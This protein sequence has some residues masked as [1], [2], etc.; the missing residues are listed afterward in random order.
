[1]RL[2]SFRTETAAAPLQVGLLEMTGTHVRAILSA[3]QGVSARVYVNDR[4]VDRGFSLQGGRLSVRL[5]AGEGLRF[6]RNLVQILVHKTH[7]YKRQSSYDIESRTVYI[8]RDAPIASAGADHTI[9]GAGFVQFDGR[10]TK[11]PPGWTRP[12]FRWRIVSAPKGSKAK[13][14]NASGSRPTL[15]PDRAG[16]F[17]VRVS[18]RGTPPRVSSGLVASDA[19]ATGASNDTAT[20]TVQPDIPPAGVRLDTLSGFNAYDDRQ[21]R[22][23]G[24]PVPG[25]GAPFTDINYAVIDRHTL[26]I[27]TSGSVGGNLEGIQQLGTIIDGYSG[28]L[29]YLVVLNW[30]S[31]GYEIDAER[32]A[33]DTVL[34]KI[35]SE[36]LTDPQRQAIQHLADSEDTNK[37]GSAV[38][39]AGAPAGSAF[40]TFAPDYTDR[41][42]GMSGYLRMNA[43]GKYDFVFTDPVE[44]DTEAN[45]TRTDISP[46]QL[47]IRVG[48]TNYT[49]PNPGGGVS[50]FHLVYL[51]AN[52]L[53]GQH[54]GVYT[55]NAADGTE[56]PGEVQRLAS[57]LNDAVNSG[58]RL[59]VILQA[60]GAPHGEDGLWD[61]AA[62][63]IERFGGAREVFD[64]LNAVDP[65]PLNG[66]NA[67]RHGP[68]AF[69]GRVGSTAPLAEASYSLNGEP[70]RLRGVLMRAHDGG[71]EPM[72]A[73]PPRSDGQSP[74]NT[75]LIHIAD[76][77]PQP[78]PAF[79]AGD[80]HPINAP[81]AQAVQQFLGGPAITGLCPTA[82]VCDIRRSYYRAAAAKTGRRSRTTLT[83]AET[84]T[85]K[86]PHERFTEAQC[87][88]IA[89]Q[90][91][92]EVSMIAKVTQYFGPLG[93]QRPS[94]PPVPPRWPT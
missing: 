48:D 55:T 24:K 32:S 49:Q 52:T 44:F 86:K 89:S 23:D 19:V 25:T 5:G 30:Y 29:D 41:G 56:Q 75:D 36:P 37:H 60:F 27:K 42:G 4:R 26:E 14:R 34:Q 46:A 59:L 62:K 31:F 33:F 35:G 88:A 45:Q 76:Q 71:Y 7:P 69:V 85:C 67:N 40:V 47:T 43:L 73:G 93:L 18:V 53:Q 87:E 63:A 68:Y 1:M 20:V 58:E 9:T 77:A 79:R 83:N 38:G 74:V 11:L 2:T 61:D 92:D 57:D 70:G 28:S 21:M 22:L 64:A 65:R 54:E 15:V 82:G 3:A 94:A 12:L 8:A 78:F 50:G 66:E 51:D 72:I 17:D 39:V 13:L 91:R 10:A 81:S 90:L 84:V 16:L 6:G 80:G